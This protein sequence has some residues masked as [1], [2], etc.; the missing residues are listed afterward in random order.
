MFS[1]K[2]CEKKKKITPRQKVI[3]PSLDKPLPKLAHRK[4]SIIN[5]F[6]KIG[7]SL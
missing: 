4:L 5:F 2:S 7:K 1:Q 3:T 6:L